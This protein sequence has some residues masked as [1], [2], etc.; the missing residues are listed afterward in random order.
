MKLYY[1][2]HIHSA[3]SPCAD[4]SMRPHDIAGMSMIKGLDVISIVDHV[5]GVNLEV[6]AR[7]ANEY[8]L[9]FLPGIE[10]TTNKGIHILCYF[11]DVKTAVDFCDMIYEIL[12]SKKNN[13][14]YFGNQYIIDDKDEIIGQV[15]K[16]LFQKTPYDVFG[17]IEL[18]KQ[19]GGAIVPAHIN[20]DIH[21]LL[22]ICDD[23]SVYNFSTV[24]VKP[25]LPID[26]K[27]LSD[28]KVVYNSDAH[29]LEA[30]SEREN[31]IEVKEKTVQAVFN[32]L[33]SK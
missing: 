27:Y 3:A 18:V 4:D 22:S 25:S 19:Y 8:G 24:E 32:Y 33:K 30:I 5:C 21:G 14:Y 11:N 31:Y 12:P 28:S 20:R 26:P 9:L 13:A 10:V 7:A 29:T 1:D 17:I 15:E 16:G 2:L 23:I 6:S